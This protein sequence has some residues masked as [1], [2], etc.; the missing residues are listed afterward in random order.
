MNPDLFLPGGEYFE[1]L[2][3]VM[4]A[5]S[6][7]TMALAV[8]STLLNRDPAAA[9]A[10]AIAEQRDTMR[11]GLSGP[12][13]RKKQLQAE[14]FMRQVVERLDLLRSIQAERINV[15]LMQAGWRSKDVMVRYL[16]M[17]VALPFVFGGVAVLY[18]FGLNVLDLETHM[19]LGVMLAAVVGGAYL[20]DL[21]VRNA[22]T[23]RQEL[24]R[25]ALP[26]ALD[27]MVVCAES[28]LS[29]DATMDR[30][31]KE[32]EKTSPE[33]ADELSLTGLE[34]GF[35]SD[36]QK[37]LKNLAVR[38]TLPAMRGIANTLAQ[39][40]KYG[41]PLAQ[42]LRVMSEES[43]LERVMKAEEKAARLP[44]LLTVP[45]ILFILPPLFV[46]LLG[47]AIIGAIEALEGVF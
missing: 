40:E 3:I 30:V 15:K 37:A 39:A 17:K 7:G 25:K 9:R 22:G 45:M 32:M 2:V 18:V 34:L 26:D 6:A 13:K 43:R 44:A 14:G 31:S 29:L 23:K 28:G 20:P 47:G 5:L 21:V 38:S 11:S 12:R 4:A 19:K 46:V 24:I 35:L 27:L 41:T 8:W 10:K 33:V 1:S 36:R 16:F 42:S